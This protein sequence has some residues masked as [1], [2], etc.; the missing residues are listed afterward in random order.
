MCEHC[1]RNINPIEIFNAIIL[2]F[3]KR[4]KHLQKLLIVKKLTVFNL[5]DDLV[6]GET[7]YRQWFRFTNLHV[8]G[9]NIMM[10]KVVVVEKTKTKLFISATVV[11]R[12]LKCTC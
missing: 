3:K 10:L 5:L 1:L 9:Y 8:L 12:N 11:Y 7:V 2:D 4:H 6:H